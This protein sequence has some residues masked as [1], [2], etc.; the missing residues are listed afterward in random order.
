MS[1]GLAGQRRVIS[2]HGVLALVDG[3]TSFNMRRRR[4]WRT[5][6]MVFSPAT[7]AACLRRIT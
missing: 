7:K 2:D 1:G 4:P 3:S 5:G 6:V